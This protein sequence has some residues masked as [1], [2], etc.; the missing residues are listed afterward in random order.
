MFDGFLSV[1][2]TPRCKIQSENK[3]KGKCEKSKKPLKYYRDG[4]LQ[5]ASNVCVHSI[6]YVFHYRYPFK[7]KM[8]STN[9]HLEHLSNLIQVWF[10]FYTIFKNKSPIIIHSHESIPI[11][12]TN[13][14][15]NFSSAKIQNNQ[16]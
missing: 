12:E 9:N 11:P 8:S 16:K 6:Q 3:I 14:I 5:K 7:Y 1:G 10:G 2:I 13:R 4:A 15:P